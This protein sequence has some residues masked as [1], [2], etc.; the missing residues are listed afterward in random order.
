M[1]NDLSRITD[2]TPKEDLPYNIYFPWLPTSRTLEELL[3]RKLCMAPQIAWTCIVSDRQS[4]YD[5]INVH[6]DKF[7]LYEA[8]SSPNPH[9]LVD[10]LHRAREIN[11]NLED[12]A[13]NKFDPQ[14]WRFHSWHDR[15]E[16][17]D[18]WI[19]SYISY[20]HTDNTR[21]TAGGMPDK[22]GMYEGLYA[23]LGFVNLYV[24]HHEL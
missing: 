11:E 17:S 7:L 12:G 4:L 19:P 8:R 24:C 20:F 6:P 14:E 5:W 3:R 13:D 21:E 9:Y 15:I 23:D 16:A 22:R 18:S 10:I 1:N 2:D